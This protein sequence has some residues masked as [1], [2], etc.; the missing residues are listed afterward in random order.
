MKHLFTLLMA[1]VPMVMSA[2]EIPVVQGCLTFKIN[3]E[4]K[5]AKLSSCDKE[6]YPESITIPQTIEYEG[7]TYPV[8]E[9]GYMAFC[10]CENLVSVVIPE[11]VTTIDW[12]VFN[13]CT[14][15][16]TVKIPNTVNKMG[17]QLFWCCQKLKSVNIPNGVTELN[18]YTFYKCNK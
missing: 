9:L 3:T 6:D 12:D 7:K 8:T 11:G 15:L 16:E 2:E 17:G 14:N 4:T 13:G 5:T 18:T 1:L 10:R